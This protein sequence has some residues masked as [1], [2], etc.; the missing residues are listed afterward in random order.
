MPRYDF[1][2]P[3]AA[4][5]NALEEFFI[6]RQ[7]EERQRMLDEMMKQRETRLL[8]SSEA[9]TANM[10]ANTASLIA[11]RQDTAADREEA[12]FTK[13]YL[14]GDVVT[15]QEA[16]AH[17]GMVQPG[18]VTQGADLGVDEQGINQYAVTQGQAT[19]RGTP[20]QRQQQQ[21]KDAIRSMI[22]Q[23]PQAAEDPQVKLM[24]QA[25]EATGEYSGLFNALG[26][27][28]KPKERKLHNVGGYLFEET[29][30]G[31]LTKVAEGREPVMNQFITPG[32]MTPTSEASVIS[33]MQNQWDTA[34]KSEREMQRNMSIMQSALQRFATDPVGG[35]E[36]VRVTFEKILDPI[37]VVREGEYARQGEGLNLMQKLEGLKQRYLTGGGPVPQSA[38]TE[39]VQTARSFMT[40]LQGF[41]AKEK[42]RIQRMAEHFKIDPMLV[43]TEEPG[44]GGGGG[45]APVGGA[46]NDPLGIL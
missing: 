10:Q 26:Q 13:R 44:G 28:S 16:T 38:L 40:G 20:A 18:K 4:A 21:Q 5:G 45:A 32:G 29:P 41:N 46:A 15:P 43:L 34:R 22:Q 37:S 25:A 42:A 35:S 3:G 17:P 24:L 23:N 27:A 8:Q 12:Q 11:Q 36:G 6:K 39:M 31:G 30:D 33:R 2:S 9:Q 14:P 1:V 7:A 19:F